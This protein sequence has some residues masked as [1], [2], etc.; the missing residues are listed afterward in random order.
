MTQSIDK[1]Y[2]I[3]M[4]EELYDTLCELRNKFDELA[5]TLNE[6][7]EEEKRAYKS[8]LGDVEDSVIDSYLEVVQKLPDV[9]RKIYELIV[10]NSN[11]IF[12]K[13]RYIQN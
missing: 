7:I 13:K 3:G 8:N 10:D 12:S 1:D 5:K 4:A 11:Y 6:G 9:E 2:E